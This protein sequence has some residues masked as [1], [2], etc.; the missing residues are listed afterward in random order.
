MKKT[1]LGA[2]ST[3]KWAYFKTT[4]EALDYLK[5]KNYTTFAIEQATNSIPLNTFKDSFEKLA[6]IFGNEVYGVE[7]EVI[8]QCEAVIEIPQAGTKHSLNI[9]VSLGIV[10]WELMREKL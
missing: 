1:A 7:Q 2:T 5:Q 4:L 10:L 3:V 6:L 8:N 9:S